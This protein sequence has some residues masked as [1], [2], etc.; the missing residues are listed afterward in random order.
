M[1]I[2]ITTPT[3]NVGSH[4][5]RLLIQAGERPTV[6]VRDSGRL[7]NDVID[8]SE[9]FEVD[10]GD[11][12]AVIAATRGA[13][14]L[15]WV[16]PPTEDDD[17]VAGYL[18]MGRSGAAAVRENRITRV[19]FQ[20]SAGAEA[21]R[22]FG[23]I[24]GLGATEALFDATDAHVS[25]LRCGY[26]YTNLLMDAD[27]IGAG[28]LATTL[29]L[30]LRFPWVDPRDIAAVAAVRLLSSSWAGRI[31]RG[32]HGPRDLSF[33]DVADILSDTVG[34]PVTARRVAEDDVASELRGFGLPEAR[35]DGILGM[36]RGIRSGFSFEDRRSILTTTPTALEAWAAE[37]LRGN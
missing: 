16:N 35:I 36:A 13:D 5:V 4:L 26:F 24:D 6:L 34:H 30:D 8:A 15:Y 22:G 20:S 14:T 9:V 33:A 17:P 19:V 28:E 18:R 25:H 27:S 37:H 32:V 7:A 12:A 11:E 10:Q 1:T 3:G 31:T 29:P 23:E 2:A 21:R